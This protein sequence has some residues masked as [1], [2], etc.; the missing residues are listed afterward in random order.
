MLQNLTGFV[1]SNRMDASLSNLLYVMNKLLFSGSE[2]PKS[3]SEASAL[4]THWT[5][6]QRSHS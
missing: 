6:L 5:S 4:R 2:C 3:P 1:L